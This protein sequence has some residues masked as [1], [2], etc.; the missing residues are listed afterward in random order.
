MK[1]MI[2]AAGAGTRLQP[3]TLETPK[4]M[5]P[6]VNRPVVHHVL[7][8]L[9]RHGARDVVMNLHSQPGQIRAYCGDGSRWGLSLRYSHEPRL[10]G[11]AGAVKRVEGFFKD[12]TFLVVSGDGLSDADLTK[13]VR[14]HKK[15]RS[16][17]TMAV[18]AVDVRFDYGVTLSNGTG[19]ITGFREKPSWGDVFS[20]RVNT[21][22]YVFEP[23]VF[24]FIP[25]GFYDFG[26]ELW[27]KLLKLGKPIYAWEHKGYWC[28]VGNLSEYRKA[29]V[30]SLT[31]KVRIH[32]PG[33]LLRPGVWAEEGSRVHP[34]AALVAPCLIG[35]GAVIESG[36]RIGPFTV[37][38]GGSRVMPKAVLKNC[39]LFDG[40]VVSRNVHLSNCIIGANGR[41]SE[42]I[43]VYEAAVLNIRR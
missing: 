11:T 40:V 27:P 31:G 39:T 43:A 14:F 4:P 8:N 9:A 28:D 32:I 15:K 3:I 6:V 22:I 25:K 42:D 10:L 26:H 18:K 38:G 37:V 33:K 30:D 41:V 1:A 16:L 29:Q 5:V 36:S 21:G 23:D 7:D 17:A 34:K 35:R 2:L 19:R 12:G 13:L 20:N 24:R